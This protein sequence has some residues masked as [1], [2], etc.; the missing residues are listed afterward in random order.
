VF[1]EEEGTVDSSDELD[2][3]NDD[4]DVDITVCD[5]DIDIDAPL[6]NFC[7]A[8]ASTKQLL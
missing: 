6:V 2:T 5:D 3:D 4:V 7:C 8:N 1:A